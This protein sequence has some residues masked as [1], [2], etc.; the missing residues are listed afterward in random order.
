MKE[1]EIDLSLE[2][3]RYLLNGTIQWPDIEEKKRPTQRNATG[4]R[5]L[6]EPLSGAPDKDINKEIPKSPVTWTNELF[7]QK[8]REIERLTE[9]ERDERFEVNQVL[10]GES[11]E[12]RP[13]GIEGRFV[14]VLLAAVGIV[15]IST[16]TYFVF[17]G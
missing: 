12:I 14:M 1:K 15:T 10:L 4:I 5:K 6:G 7:Q 9:N 8:N 17:A 2:E 16:W 13:H 11:K 3:I